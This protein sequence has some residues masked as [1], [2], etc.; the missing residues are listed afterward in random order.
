M[1][2]SWIVAGDLEKID[3]AGLSRRA[4]HLCQALALQE[5]VDERGLS[6]V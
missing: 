2:K 3:E 6:D 5:R 4:A 1:R